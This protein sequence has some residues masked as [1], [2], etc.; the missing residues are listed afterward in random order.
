MPEQSQNDPLSKNFKNYLSSNL[1]KIKP[2]LLELPNY[3]FF[4]T[5]MKENDKRNSRFVGRD[6][7]INKILSFIHETSSNTGSYLITGFRGMGKTSVVNKAL[8]TL[9]SKPKSLRFVLL[10]LALMPFVFMS[11]KI[12]R[13]ID[14][15]KFDTSGDIIVFLLLLVIICITFVLLGKENFRRDKVATK[16]KKERYFQFF[17]SGVESLLNP[18][19]NKS[20]LLFYS[21]LRD[22]FIYCATLSFYT[23]CTYIMWNALNYPGN[24]VGGIQISHLSFWTITLGLSLTYP[25]IDLYIAFVE[26][27]KDQGSDSPLLRGQILGAISIV[28]LF[29]H[30]LFM[31]AVISKWDLFVN[32]SDSDFLIIFCGV[33]VIMALIVWAKYQILSRRNNRNQKVY[34]SVLSRIT[35]FFNFQHYITVNVNLGKDKLTEKDVLKYITNEL[36]KVYSDWF[37]N[38]KNL[39]RF[40]NISGLLTLLYLVVTIFYIGF[41]GSE[42]STFSNKTI[43]TSYYFPS[44]SL[45]VSRQGITASEVGQLFYFTDPDTKKT[46]QATL[47][48]YVSKIDSELTAYYRDII[49]KKNKTLNKNI[50]DSTVNFNMDNIKLFNEAVY[51][52]SHEDKNGNRSIWANV[53]YGIIQVCNE[54]DY[55]TLKFWINL[56]RVLFH[57]HFDNNSDISSKLVNTIYPS[58]PILF[59]YFFMILFLISLR[60]IP[61]RFILIS[62]HF[63]T[64]LQLK[65]IKKQIEASITYEENANAVAMQSSLFNFKKKTDYLPL[66]SKD[67][68]QKLIHLLDEVDKISALFIKVKFV[69]V[70]DELDKINPHNTVVLSSKEDEFETDHNE[71]RYQARR[72][73][74]IAL[75]LSSMKHF[76]NSSKAKFIFIAGREMYDAALAGIS[77]RESSLDSIFSDNKIYVH[78]FYT[79]EAD[80]NKSDI[81][82]ITEQYLCQFLIPESFLSK[83]KDKPSLN[84]YNQYLSAYY[85][86]KNIPQHDKKRQ[87]IITTLK[88]FIVYLSYRSN[89]A[90]RKL[91]NLIEQYVKP[92]LLDDL[93]DDNSVI[94]GRNDSNLYLNIGYYDQYKFSLIS[95]MTTPIFLGIGN[96]LHE[97]SDK[98]LVSISY[99]LDHLYKFHK[100]GISYR[101]LSLTPEIIDINKEPQFREFLDKL[102]QSLSQSHLRPIVS[103]IYDYKFHSKISSEIKFLSKIDELEGAALNFTL[104]E[105]IELK[106][107]F[108][109]RLEQLTN[110][111]NNNHLSLSI[112]DEQHINNKG[113]LHVMIGDLHFYDEEYHEAISHYLE[114]IQNLRQISIREMK[115]YDFI[116]FV[117]NKLKL[118]L[119]YEKNKMYDNAL[120]TYSELTDLIL[121]KRNMPIRKFGLARFIVTPSQLLLIYKSKSGTSLEKISSAERLHNLKE[122]IDKVAERFSQKKKKSKEL[123]FTTS[124]FMQKELVVLG[125]LKPEVVAEIDEVD[126]QRHSDKWKRIYPLSDMEVYYGLNSEGLIQDLDSIDTNYKPLKNYFLQSTLE[127]MRLLYQPLI[128]KLHM[129][130]KSGSDK[131][132]DIDI[133]RSIEEFNFIKRPLKTNEKRVVVSEFYN[134]IGDLLYFK[135]GTLNKCLK[136]QILTHLERLVSFKKEDNVKTIANLEQYITSELTTLLIKNKKPRNKKIKKVR[137]SIIFKLN[138]LTPLSDENNELKIKELET[139]VRF[140]LKLLKSS[141]KEELQRNLKCLIEK[142]THD[143]HEINLLDKGVSQ[144]QVKSLKN[145]LL[146]PIDATVFYIKS[147]AVLLIPAHE[148]CEK[149]LEQLK[150][151]EVDLLAYYS[152]LELNTHDNYYEFFKVLGENLKGIRMKLDIITEKNNYSFKERYTQEYLSSIANGT[153]DLAEALSSFVIDSYTNENL[154]NQFSYIFKNIGLKL[155]DI[156]CLYYEA[157]EIYYN[158]GSYRLAKSQLL[159]ILHIL[160]EATIRG[161]CKDLLVK[162][163]KIVKDK[164]IKDILEVAIKCVYA[165]YGQS[166]FIEGKKISEFFNTHNFLEY[167]VKSSL[168]KSNVTIEINEIILLYW[169]IKLNK[170]EKDKDHDILEFYQMITKNI[171]SLS[172]IRRKHNRILELRLKLKINR[173]MFDRYFDKLSDHHIK[174]GSKDFEEY[175]NSESLTKD[176][177]KT[178]LILDSLGANTEVLK[179]HY[180][181]DINYVTTNHN[182]LAKAHLSMSYWSMQFDQLNKK[183]SYTRT[184]EDQV[185]NTKTSMNVNEAYHLSLALEFNKKVQDFHSRG[186][187]YNVFIKSA[188][189]LDDFFNDNLIHFSLAVERNTIHERECGTDLFISK[190]EGEINLLKVGKEKPFDYNFYFN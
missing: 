26:V 125:R 53:H 34:R 167:N 178:F 98:L 46:R 47:D 69:F 173:I 40:L 65:N 159:K 36:Y 68:T 106:R 120:M 1:F 185:L 161:K 90:P 12:V 23:C 138:Q 162:N 186:E 73:E 82:S 146:S 157:F 83:V 55:L 101:S 126:H 147:L 168:S 128:A 64:L 135:N 114:S 123:C 76:L 51:W 163:C 88:D 17:K 70:F 30:G 81:T 5:S 79:E 27:Q 85:T 16:D 7:I 32:P 77:D 13:F 119:A 132:K 80:G 172:L 28:F 140:G 134:K 75:I 113:L 41:L 8:G 31:L 181:F 3:K 179:S 142:L 108:N 95:S 38:Y 130:E 105:S 109:K 182:Q 21:N 96:F 29:S 137:Q 33:L 131:L 45:L 150:S 22:V 170:I 145:L 175:L 6:D 62:T 94:V 18:K 93:I 110:N 67:I 169:R 103:G 117:R 143:L 100:F 99:M 63:H 156:L 37:T 122:H 136:K 48:E 165:T 78:S 158:I 66:E 111:K 121:R 164:T 171:N 39:K 56:K 25:L 54:L 42:F 115:L 15:I 104:D 89:G 59:V 151:N 187:S 190:I 60:L 20:K 74:R 44:Q 176:E 188:S 183:G 180:L 166:H 177:F 61:K 2:I 35:G 86:E 9:N 4:H 141:K 19:F 49:N 91:S 184:L 129:I 148:V 52:K 189:Y 154:P 133:T 72:K 118:G 155:K 139:Q 149:D 71:V 58:V 84:L 152:A 10:W 124:N 144:K 97:Y 57:D 11:S 92:V 153:I 24:E 87:K 14:K 127:N 43:S 160:R 116:L 50:P 107:Y 102:V 112:N 174:T